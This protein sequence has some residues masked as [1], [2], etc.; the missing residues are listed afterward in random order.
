MDL[1]VSRVGDLLEQKVQRQDRLQLYSRDD[2]DVLQIGPHLLAVNR[3]APYKSWEQ[4]EPQIL[5]A[6]DSYLSVAKPN[7]LAR[8]DLRCINR[9]EI[10]GPLVN[11]E[12][13]FDFYPYL[14]KKLPQEIGPYFVGVEFSFVEGRDRLRLEMQ[15]GASEK[16]DVNTT[17]LGLDY[18]CQNSAAFDFAAIRD[19][20]RNA[21][22]ALD[23]V[24]E[25]CIR[26][27]LRELFVA[28]KAL[29]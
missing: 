23:D 26:D 9:I 29:K 1:A 5:A 6:L 28:Q 12:E 8:I 27:P 2:K 7:G 15:S 21:H 3:L 16:P 25:G 20:L 22:R 19:W 14:G 10:P 24:F 17:I 11:Q 4:F 13:Y 18:Y